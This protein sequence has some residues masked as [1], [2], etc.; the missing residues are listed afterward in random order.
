MNALLL[1]LIIFALACC[2]TPGP[3]NIML[4]ASGANFGFRRTIPHI[5]GVVAGVAVLMTSTAAGLGLV[6]S[7]FPQLQWILKIIGAAYLLYLAWKIATIP[8]LGTAKQE[9]KP[10]TFWQAALFQFLNPKALVM[11]FS[12]MT[13]FTI[14]GIDY[15]PSATRVVLVFTIICLPSISCWAGFGVAISGLLKNART[16]RIFNV[17]LGTVTALSVFFMI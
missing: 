13:T 9:G 15:V 6:F 12:A 1:P 8:A 3:N 17:S 2:I 10:F 16:F 5:M 4:T 11:T 7:R 14:A